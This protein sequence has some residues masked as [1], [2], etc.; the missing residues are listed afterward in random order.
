MSGLVLLVGQLGLALGGFI[1][2]SKMF[3]YYHDGGGKK[4]VKNDNKF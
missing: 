2:V 4:N 3:N 1:G